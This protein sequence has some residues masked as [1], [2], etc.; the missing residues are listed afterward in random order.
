MAGKFSTPIKHSVYI[1][2]PPARVYETLTTK[3][4]WDAWFTT[5]MELD[6]KPRGKI[7]FRWESWGPEKVTVGDEGTITEFG[8]NSYLSFQWHP[9][10]KDRPTT[11]EFRLVPMGKG[12]HLKLKEDGFLDTPEGHRS[13]NSCATGWGEALTLLKFY[14]EEGLVYRQP[15]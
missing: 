15:V 2:A 4:G 6:L 7:H 12:T 13:F 3:A 11:V 5:E 9:Q 8:E 10:G 1:D 14:L